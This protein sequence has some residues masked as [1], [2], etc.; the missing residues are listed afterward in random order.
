MSLNTIAEAIEALK[1][2][3]F[4]LVVDNA[5][6]ENEG[7]LI[8]AAETVT[9]SKIAFMVRYTS[10]LICLSTTGA[11]LDELDLPLMVMDNTES[12]QTAFTVSID[13]KIGTTTGISAA[14]RAAAAEPWESRVLQRHRPRSLALRPHRHPFRP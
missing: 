12:H 5:Q 1:A 2:G 11:R 10:G 6:R 14:D 4:V 8:I 3:G 13:Y 9:A 7:D